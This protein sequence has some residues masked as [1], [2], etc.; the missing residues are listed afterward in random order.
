MSSL[1]FTK[2]HG[3]EN[4]FVLLLPPA[5]L[6]PS[7]SLPAL[8]RRVCARRTGVGADGLITVDDASR[9]RV[10]NADGSEAEMCGNGIRAAVWALHLRAPA[11][12]PRGITLHTGRGALLSTVLSPGVV[13]VDMGAPLSVALDRGARSADVSMGNPHRVLF[14][15][16]RAE[17]DALDLEAA[18]RRL[19]PD[20]RFN[21][22]VA[23]PLPGSSECL[24]RTWERGVGETRACGTG[25]CAVAVSGLRLG[26]LSGA[27]VAVALLGG[28]LRVRWA[29]GDG[30]PVFMA[31]PAEVTFEGSLVTHE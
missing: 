26:V 23:L 16:S 15:A 17:W 10:F 28:E 22:E 1:A 6:P 11:P 8:A 4:D 19:D 7:A 5:P 14:L 27:E 2:A 3:A 30:D 24:Q 29:G 21:V 20:G 12:L 25:A 18:A 9:M 13:E 31:G